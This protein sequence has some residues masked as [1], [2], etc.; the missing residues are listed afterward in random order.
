MPPPRN[1]QLRWDTAPIK[2]PVG[3]TM[4]ARGRS[5]TQA[6]ATQTAIPSAP[7]KLGTSGGGRPKSPR[8]AGAVPPARGQIAIAA[9]SALSAEPRQDDLRAEGSCI[10]MQVAR[11]IGSSPYCAAA[12]TSTEWLDVPHPGALRHRHPSRFGCAIVLPRTRSD[13]RKHSHSHFG[14]LPEGWFRNCRLSRTH[15]PSFRCCMYGGSAAPRRRHS[16]LDSDRRCE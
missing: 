16:E 12:P 1:V 8:S 5:A 6:P 13:S 3:G 7:R 9:A 10:T 2:R 4:P 15:L 11:R 14:N